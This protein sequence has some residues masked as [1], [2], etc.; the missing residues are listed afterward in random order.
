LARVDDPSNLT[1]FPG[2]VGGGH[3]SSSPRRFSLARPPRPSPTLQPG[4]HRL[5]FAHGSGPFWGR[6]IEGIATEAFVCCLGRP[7]RSKTG[8]SPWIG[9]RIG[10]GI[11]EKPIGP[12]RVDGPIRQGV[13]GPHD[14]CLRFCDEPRWA[15]GGRYPA[16]DSAIGDS[17]RSD[18]CAGHDRPVAGSAGP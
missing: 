10:Q 11:G 4:R 7:Q 15:G 8:H 12:V 14:S 2:R 9:R 17:S 18:T 6:D 5:V 16:N 1:S 13:A 3:R